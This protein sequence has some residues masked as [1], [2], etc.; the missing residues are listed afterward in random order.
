MTNRWTNLP[1]SEQRAKEVQS[2][3]GRNSCFKS[4]DSC[5]NLP[6]TNGEGVSHCV[7]GRETLQLQM[8]E[9]RVAGMRCRLAG[10]GSLQPEVQPGANPQRFFGATLQERFAGT[11][12]G[13]SKSSWLKQTAGRWSGL[14]AP[15]ARPR[16]KL[17]TNEISED[18][19][20]C[21]AAVPPFEQPGGKQRAV[22]FV[23]VDPDDVTTTVRVRHPN[24]SRLAWVKCTDCDKFSV[25]R[26]VPFDQPHEVPTP[27]ARS[28]SGSAPWLAQALK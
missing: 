15:A 1:P 3:A 26:N 24:R 19:F 22:I 20:D 27:N 4:R 11:G 16:E 28:G 7:D 18:Q 17:E 23:H 13:T 10:R 25:R 6:R 14:V 8:I 9:R 2:A 12:A 5:A 21:L